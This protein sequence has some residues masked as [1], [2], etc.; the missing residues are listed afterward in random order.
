MERKDLQVTICINNRALIASLNH[1][2]INDQCRFEETAEHFIT[3]CGMVYRGVRYKK[4]GV[5][6]VCILGI[7]K[8]SILLIW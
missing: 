1:R 3:L 8:I 6:R 2:S 5:G 4:L 7:W